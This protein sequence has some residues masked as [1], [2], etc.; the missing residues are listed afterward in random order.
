MQWETLER[1]FFKML[2]HCFCCLKHLLMMEANIYALRLL[3]VERSLSVQFS[4]TLAYKSH[5][6]WPI[7]FDMFVL[8]VA[9]ESGLLMNTYQRFKKIP[10]RILKLDQ[11]AQSGCPVH[12]TVERDE[13]T[14]KS[15]VL[16]LQCAMTCAARWSVLKKLHIIP[17]QIIKIRTKLKDVASF[18]K[19][20]FQCS[21]V[22]LYVGLLDARTLFKTQIKHLQQHEMWNKYFSGLRKLKS[23]SK[24]L[25]FEIDIHL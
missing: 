12:I 18:L 10:R 20:I 25:S 21:R 5:L 1:Y 19:L 7:A 9:V 4:M 14:L 3:W 11:I 8:S 13:Y 24:N 2:L 23:F 6:I 17:K 16:A 22:S 15:L